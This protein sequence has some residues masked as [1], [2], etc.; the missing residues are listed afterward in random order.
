MTQPRSHFRLVTVNTAPQRAKLLIGR[1]VEA[2][3]DDYIIDHIGNCESIQEV[4]S[5]VR[6][7]KPDVLL[8]AQ[9]DSL[10][11][12]LK[13][14]QTHP[15][16][17][18]ADADV[19]HDFA[20]DPAE[21]HI[22]LPRSSHQ[23]IP[24]LDAGPTPASL[25]HPPNE[26]VS[27]VNQHTRNMEFYGSSSSMALLSHVHGGNVGNTESGTLLSNLHNPA[28]TPP[29][30]NRKA[31]TTA[32][33]DV[34]GRAAH[35]PQCR[36]FLDNHF[37]A[38]HYIHPVLDKAEFFERCEALWTATDDQSPSFTAL[39]YS[40][41]SVGAITS[42]RD[43]EP[44]GGLDNLQWSRFLFKEATSRCGQLNMVTDL[45]MVQSYL[46]LAKV[47]QNEIMPHWAYM[48]IGMAVRTALAIGINRSSGPNTRKPPA[49]LRA[50]SRT[51]WGLYSLETET[52]FAMGRPDTLGADLYHNQRY[53]L[54]RG[55]DLGEADRLEP[56]HCAIIKSMVDFS[57]ITRQVC[58]GVYLTEFNLARTLDT[59]IQME[60][61][62]NNWI[63]AL[64]E[65]IRPR[66]YTDLMPSLQDARAPRWMKRQRLVLTIRYHNLRILMFGTLLLRSTKEERLAI[67]ASQE[68]V[69]KC[70][71]S[72]KRTIET[73]YETLQHND[74]FR[75]WFYN[76]TYIVFAASIILVYLTREASNATSQPLHR[77]VGLAIDILELMSES[78]V[79]QEAAKMLRRAKE[80]VEQGPEVSVEV[81]EDSR[82]LNQ[83][84]G[85]L[86]LGTED[87]DFDMMFQL[88]GYDNDNFLMPFEPQ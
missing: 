25:M 11:K 10:S 39:Y 33:D 9:V 3:K 34:P 27:G 44:L 53:P 54:I 81:I 84:W 79:A 31:A 6:E 46:F 38:L 87:V 37:S 51:W 22:E 65:D 24:T 8:E 66:L 69:Q 77:L 30:T 21:D 60:Q 43:D 85:R 61:S 68:C 55:V 41:L 78:V 23:A 4:E 59:A 20:R 32:K 49:Q 73:I 7:F 42:P 13:T 56:P 71:D 62:L 86:E 26:E 19:H 40:V 47:C 57:R 80:A 64:P 45:N 83:Y 35:F 58:F 1:V 17:A 29:E 70:L 5:K 14:Q 16:T 28:F 76:T 63:S 48:Y 75:T 52:S 67:P 2:L 36:G 18:Q 50:E 72:A 74:F 88:S 82:L 15:P 12:L